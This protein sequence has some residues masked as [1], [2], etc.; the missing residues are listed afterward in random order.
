MD[1]PLTTAGDDDRN[2][3]G[4]HMPTI[5]RNDPCHCGS[6]KKYKKCHE[7]N[8]QSS[9]I[10]ANQKQWTEAEK[11]FEKEKTEETEAEKAAAD[12]PGSVAPQKTEPAKAKTQKHTKFVTPKYNM[13]RKAGGGG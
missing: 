4:D 1:P 10:A 6:G 12:K 2:R 13:P 11:K 7:A 3:K 5:G 9:E 8:D